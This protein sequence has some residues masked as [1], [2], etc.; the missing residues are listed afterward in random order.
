MHADVANE[1]RGGGPAVSM[2]PLPGAEFSDGPLPV[3][4]AGASAGGDGDNGGELAEA[5]ASPCGAGACE[6]PFGGAAGDGA[7]ASGGR[8][9]GWFLTANTTMINF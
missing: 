2:T 4:G 1:R 3:A 9:E 5:G 6:D 8:G 7:F